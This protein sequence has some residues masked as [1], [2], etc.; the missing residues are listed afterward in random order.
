MNEH[1][2]KMAEEVFFMRLNRIESG[3]ITGIEI[4]FNGIW[5]SYPYDYR[6]GFPDEDSPECYMY[7][8]SA[9]HDI[10]KREFYREDY[11]F[12][13]KEELIKSLTT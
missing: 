7:S 9:K 10:E 3:K 2:Y 12:K 1:K 4:T 11:V 5:P 6:A 13:T 8:V